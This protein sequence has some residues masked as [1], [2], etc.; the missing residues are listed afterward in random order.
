MSAFVTRP[1]IENSRWYGGALLSF[2]A[3]GEQTGG[4]YALLQATVRGGESVPA[5]VHAHEDE[6]F[7]ILDGVLRC[8]VG[9]GTIHAR[10]G[11]CVFLPRGIP[12]AWD[13]E[14]DVARFLVLISPAGFERSFF[15]F[16]TPASSLT[17]PPDGP[18]P[19][20]TVIEALVAR[21]RELGV[22]YV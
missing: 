17:L 11:D 10:P 18:P 6:S 8:H 7:V 14:S 20:A 22:V 16:S 15:E 9:A 21:E 19:D 4:A 13:V 3:S 12:H 2:I 1:L 5:H